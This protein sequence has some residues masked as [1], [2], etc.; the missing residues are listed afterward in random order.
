MKKIMLFFVALLGAAM[1]IMA[2]VDPFMP[3]NPVTLGQGGSFTASAEGYN[4]F[5]FNPA[6]FAKK[7]ELTV[8][9]INPYGI[10]DVQMF[11]LLM[12]ILG[13][14]D[15]LAS[16]DSS[17][18][19]SKDFSSDLE[20]A[21][22]GLTDL[23]AS[24]SDGL[25]SFI[26]DAGTDNLNAGIESLIAS[27]PEY[28]DLEDLITEDMSSED[29][30]SVVLQSGID[31]S[32]LGTLV[33]DLIAEVAD[34]AGLNAA[35]YGL[36]NLG[37]DMDVAIKDL[38]DVLNSYFPSGNMR[39]GISTGIGWVGGGLGLGAFF[40][41][42]ANIV[43]PDDSSLLSATGSILSTVSFVGGGAFEL[44]DGFNLGFSI[45]PTFLA[46]AN[47]DPLTVMS[48]FLSDSSDTTQVLESILASSLYRGVYL[49]VDLGALW[50]LGP[51]TLGAALKDVL[52]LPITYYSTD[53]SDMDAAV[54]ASKLFDF[55]T[56]LLVGDSSDLYQVP[57][58]KLN[59]GAQFHPD[60][61]SINDLL[62]LRVGLDFMDVF[63]FLRDSST[64]VALLGES[65]DFLDHI[66]LG[67]QLKLLNFIS[68]RAGFY[69]AALAG[70]VGIQLPIVDL[71]I[72]GVL[73][74]LDFE[75]G[76]FSEIG[77]SIEV[78]IRFPDVLKSDSEN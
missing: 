72:A 27:N 41:T 8:L 26:A 76:S 18:A 10:M 29:L 12:S 58:M 43:T 48:Q 4:A 28:S 21:S 25:T 1:P 52:P 14:D 49:G 56:D 46:Y 23:L 63:G 77:A 64:D 45:R 66:N 6:G 2:Q 78:A 60:L 22:S 68:I 17:K 55:S 50:D 11:D 24:V 59:L 71:N 75:T 65:Y 30:I 16:A 70:G 36:E 37:T 7:S 44:F 62:D 32:E 42:E 15:P 19:I 53:L 67:A 51:F 74:D 47:V 13:G 34:A 9:S 31:I 54:I 38:E 5:F 61:G 73:S 3:L 69:Q 35:D 20:E 39:F 33:D 57:A 40:S